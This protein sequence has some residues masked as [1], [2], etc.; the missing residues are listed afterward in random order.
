MLITEVKKI[1]QEKLF[2]S[3]MC[4]ILWISILMREFSLH[5]IRFNYILHAN[6]LEGVYINFPTCRGL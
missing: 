5:L 6:L 2:P 1:N 3:Y 4:R